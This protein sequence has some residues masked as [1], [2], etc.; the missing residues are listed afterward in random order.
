VPKKVKHHKA[1]KP[2][3]EEPEEETE[4]PVDEA[5]VD[6]AP[7]EAELEGETES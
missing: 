4:A 1:A 2:V 3:V 5:P 7:V 6:E